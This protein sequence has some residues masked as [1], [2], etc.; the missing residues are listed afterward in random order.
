M[1]IENLIS[2]VKILLLPFTAGGKRL[3]V[4]QANA[5]YH[6]S[7]KLPTEEVIPMTIILLSA[8]ILGIFIK[9]IF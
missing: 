9:E 8:I 3:A 5:V 2:R 7:V 1:T 4:R 6:V